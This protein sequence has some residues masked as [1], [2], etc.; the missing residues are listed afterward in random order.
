VQNLYKE[1]EKLLPKM[2]RKRVIKRQG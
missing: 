2:K 1:E